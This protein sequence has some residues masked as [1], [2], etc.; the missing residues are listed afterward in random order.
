M[1]KL[2]YLLLAVSFTALLIGCAEE[3]KEDS[4][5]QIDPDAPIVSEE[6]NEIK[7]DGKPHIFDRSF[8][9]PFNDVAYLSIYS[10]YSRGEI[11]FT[12]QCGETITHDPD[13]GQQSNVNVGKEI[14]IGK[15]CIIT[16][17]YKP[18][19]LAKSSAELTVTFKKNPKSICEKLNKPDNEIDNKTKVGLI[20]N[21]EE[22][23]RRYE[24]IHYAKKG[25]EV[26]HK[27]ET[28]NLG[29][30]NY[31]VSDYYNGSN[32]EIP[33][34]KPKEYTFNLKQG[35]YDIQANPNSFKVATGVTNCKIVT[36]QDEYG[37]DIK[38]LNVTNNNGCKVNIESA[39][40]ITLSSK[41]REYYY[42]VEID[43]REY[44]TVSDYINL[45]H[46]MKPQ[47]SNYPP[48]NTTEINKIEKDT[49]YN[50]TGKNATMF[51]I[52]PTQYNGCKID[53]RNKKITGKNCFVTF[54][55]TDEAK[56]KPTKENP[57]EAKITYTGLQNNETT[58]Y[59][60]VYDN[61][62]NS[63]PDNMII[64]DY[65]SKYCKDK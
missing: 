14:A 40:S 13:L 49:T 4:T 42:E 51:K 8:A 26:A 47:D 11:Q 22:H 9:N 59:G 44:Y 63:Y 37:Y 31:K 61:S 16:Y 56:K 28:I 21:I 1:K 25:S 32:S 33:G 34:F 24:Y 64:E 17:E 5:Q 43:I 62:G 45:S 41:D 29:T 38:K 6:T 23:T 19:K 35:E 27:G 39:D 18:T 10:S 20:D 50:I 12:K 46:Y 30:Y 60:S 48:R 53:E 2:I 7:P 52:V 58:L 54:E 36:T 65:K 55:L 3:K 15:D 57:Y